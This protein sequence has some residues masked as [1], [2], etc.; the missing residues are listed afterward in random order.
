[1]AAAILKPPVTICKKAVKVIFLLAIEGRPNDDVSI[2]FEF[3]K[4]VAM[5][6]NLV[7]TLYEAKD[8][9]DF[10]NHLISISTSIEL[11]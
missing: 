1:M 6:E 9:T 5:N 10:L 11:F 7:N 8:E 3:F 2:L 4:Q